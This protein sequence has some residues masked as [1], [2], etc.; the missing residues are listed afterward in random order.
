M[1]WVEISWYKNAL[2]R[3]K[4]EK[5]AVGGGMHLLGTQE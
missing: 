4:I 5:I 1:Y 3:K 2:G